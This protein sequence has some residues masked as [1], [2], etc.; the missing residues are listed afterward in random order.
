MAPYSVRELF[1]TY[2]PLTKE[3]TILMNYD[4]QNENNGISA[5]VVVLLIGLSL[6]AGYAL[7]YYNFLGFSRTKEV[8][9]P[10]KQEAKERFIV[11]LGN[12]AKKGGKEPKVVIVAFSDYECPFCQKGD[13]TMDE[14]LKKYGD[15][16]AI[17]H[18]HYPLISM[19]P[20]AQPAAKAALAAR[21]QGE[22]HFWDYHQKLF[23][24]R[25]ELDGPSLLKYAKEI[26]LDIQKFQDDLKNNDSKYDA[27]IAEDMR[28]ASSLNVTGTPA[29]FVNGIFVSGA[30]PLEAFSKII[31][32]E[33]HLADK[34][35]SS[36]ITPS[37]LYNTITKDAKAPTV[38][39]Q[40]PER[41]QYVQD[42]TIYKVPIENSPFDG[43][44]DAPITLVAFSDFKCGYCA[45]AETTL[46]ALRDKYK[47]LL[48]IVYKQALTVS[49]DDTLPSRAF[50]AA[51]TMGKGEEIRSWLYANARTLSKETIL[52]WAKTQ[53]LSEK[54]F[55]DAMNSP[56]YAEQITSETGLFASLNNRGTPA[57][58][59]NG[60]VIKGNQP[61]GV[62]TDLID[63]LLEEHT[64][65][66]A[67][68]KIP[69][70]N[71]YDFI[72]K[73]AKTSLPS[74][75]SAQENKEKPG[76]VRVAI[77][78][79]NG[80]S[81]GNE[82]APVTI[83]VVS[84]F[85]CPFCQKGAATIEKIKSLY[86][87]SVR[88]VF[89]N[90]PLPFHNMAKP[91]ALAALSAH[92]QN[93]FWEMHNLLFQNQKEWKT[94]DVSM[95]TYAKQLG[96]DVE[97]FKAAMNDPALLKDIEDDMAYTTGLTGSVGTPTFYINGR[98]LE[99]AQPLEIFK[100]VID[101][102]IAAASAQGKKTKPAKTRKSSLAI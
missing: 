21:E 71:Y 82:K 79:G 58:F 55:D 16:L 7:G 45:K 94:G 78:P 95:E 60:R 27:A 37:N 1:W 100:Q 73:E 8:T 70:K 87:T 13:A 17:Y 24:N 62:F 76:A 33:I 6:A 93:K 23:A 4:S 9:A 98:K 74:E 40:K 53:G 19:H 30:Q 10:L 68:K 12:A 32:E 31:D 26:N 36:G 35:L 92:K 29:F 61:I 59:V 34:L 67:D 57:F 3:G 64:K 72:Q 75:G 42:M 48:R 65:T 51:F 41:K 83:V 102:E 47:N 44:A 20:N 18:R 28:L 89:R 90:Y 85:Q 54:K 80:P 25:K 52:A 84:D 46:N 22:N 69:A 11:P 81:W 77:E 5:A 96:L 101:E 66:L 15:T 14:L 49:G 43:K 86:D 39:R 38:I 63:K 91:A 99:G 2:G 50:L 56:K 88:V 97:K